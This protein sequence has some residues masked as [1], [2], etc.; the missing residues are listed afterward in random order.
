MIPLKIKVQSV[1]PDRDGAIAIAPL[2][3]QSAGSLG[4]RLVCQNKDSAPSWG[5][6]WVAGG[7]FKIDRYTGNGPAP[8]SGVALEQESTL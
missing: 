6:G 2:N 4:P 5:E 1:S 7:G 3:G 8:G